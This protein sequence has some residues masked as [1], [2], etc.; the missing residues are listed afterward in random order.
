MKMKLNSSELITDHAWLVG[1]YL[2][3]SFS[4]DLYQAGMVGL[5]EAAL[6]FDPEL[7]NAFSTY[8]LYWV[9]REIGA[10]RKKDAKF[11]RL[12]LNE[13]PLTSTQGAPQI[14]VE[15]L[16]DLKKILSPKLWVIFRLKYGR[17][18]DDATIA[19]EYGCTR[20]WINLQV[21]Q[22]L[23]LVRQAH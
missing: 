23:K 17:G 10:Q 9:R 8:A 3:G 20:Q 18:L 4:P 13:E 15:F 11:G 16:L 5:C 12:I 14:I 21:Q 19:R 7:G 1:W 2:K 22:G 6:R